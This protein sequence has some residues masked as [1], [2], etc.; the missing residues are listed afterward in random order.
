[1]T[2][3]WSTI[4]CRPLRLNC[5]LGVTL[6]EQHFFVQRLGLNFLLS[7]WLLLFLTAAIFLPVYS[8][9][10]VNRRICG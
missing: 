5:R 9:A 2:R 6:R 7:G 3:S 8:P 1:M 10:S 4:L